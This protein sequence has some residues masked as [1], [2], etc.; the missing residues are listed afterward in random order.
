M[1]ANTALSGQSNAAYTGGNNVA[2]QSYMGNSADESLEDLKKV[3]DADPLNI[4]KIMLLAQ[5]VEWATFRPVVDPKA[6]DSK[7]FEVAIKWYS[8]DTPQV[9]HGSRMEQN[10]R[11]TSK[12]KA[13]NE[14]QPLEISLECATLEN[15]ECGKA[16]AT[17][18][19]DNK[20]VGGIEFVH[21]QKLL[22][23]LPS[24]EVKVEDLSESAKAIYS[25]TKGEVVDTTSFA[26]IYGRSAVE[27]KSMA[28]EPIMKY[29]SL[30]PDGEML[31]VQVDSPALK[32]LGRTTVAGNSGKGDVFFIQQDDKGNT[33]TVNP[34][35]KTPT[36]PPAQKSP[37]TSKAGPV[38]SR[39]PPAAK[40]PAPPAPVVRKTVEFPM[41]LT[42]INSKVAENKP[43][44]P[45]YADGS[46]C[47]IAKTKS[48]TPF[49]KS[50]LDEI[51]QTCDRDGVK[52]ARR[53][54]TAKKDSRAENFMKLY[55]ESTA[56]QKTTL[57]P[58]AKRLKIDADTLKAE[59]FPD[60]MLVT[61]V[62]ESGFNPSAK[63]PIS[64]AYGEW[65]FLCGTAQWLGFLEV[66]P[67]GNCKNKADITRD[68]RIFG[69]VATKG[70]VKYMKQFFAKFK[71]VDP[72]TGEERQ[73]IP[74][75]IASYRVGSGP[76]Q[77][78]SDA[79]K[80]HPITIKAQ[81]GAVTKTYSYGKMSPAQIKLF[82]SNFFYLAENHIGFQGKNEKDAVPYTYET[83][84]LMHIF[85]SPPDHGF[86]NVEAI[87]AD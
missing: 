7:E 18:L 85:L 34:P 26:V 66:V 13:K 73:N 57:S 19:E 38:E 82:P 83:L 43:K 36:P 84:A 27:V 35:A 49:T 47:P 58:L 32:A 23:P 10:G 20:V 24:T 15:S 65:Q 1:Q 37:P 56:P 41:V 9:F 51:V 79:A 86:P 12:L 61:A 33:T 16:Q 39:V 30:D 62:M 64:T 21:E 50:I 72:N 74:M 45:Q 25:N 46:L 28:G 4:P 44:P 53:R 70:F 87:S 60:V 31:P 81:G 48:A 8:V 54:L 5:K 11:I 63:S 6:K 68:G 52:A 78:A 22:K 75:A 80:L 29:D 69:D 42:S 77:D 67:G 17:L 2:G 71:Y 59:Q 55:K 40:P 3:V 76:T 14:G